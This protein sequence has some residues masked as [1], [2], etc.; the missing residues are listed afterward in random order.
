ML[1][2]GND[3]SR[4]ECRHPNPE[5]E[6]CRGPM[7]P[8]APGGAGIQRDKPGLLISPLLVLLPPSPLL[9]PALC[10]LSAADASRRQRAGKSFTSSRPSPWYQGSVI[11]REGSDPSPLTSSPI[12]SKKKGVHRTRPNENEHKTRTNIGQ[13]MKGNNQLEVTTKPGASKQARG[14]IRFDALQHSVPRGR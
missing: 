9:C 3:K 11:N 6:C 10:D 2:L 5:E 7:P 8:A 1:L 13:K 12:T 14:R 4:R